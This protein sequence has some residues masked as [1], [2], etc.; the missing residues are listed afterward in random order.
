[1]FALG[2]GVGGKVGG[3]VWQILH[4]CRAT[5]T[6]PTFHSVS[7]HELFPKPSQMSASH[8]S[9]PHPTKGA[10]APLFRSTPLQHCACNVGMGVGS[11]VIIG[12]LV[13]AGVG[14]GVGADVIGAAVGVCVGCENGFRVV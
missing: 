1:V 3:F 9:S 14:F 7:Q 8:S 11:G 10:S 5:L 4:S 6:H 2:D 12:A 13:G